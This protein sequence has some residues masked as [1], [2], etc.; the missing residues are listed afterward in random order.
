MAFKQII[1]T[2]YL[3]VSTVKTSPETESMDQ[4]ESGSQAKSGSKMTIEASHVRLE[5]VSESF[6]ENKVEAPSYA[7]SEKSVF[8]FL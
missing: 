3:I 7:E 6:S 8:L 5:T 1:E 2:V 4:I